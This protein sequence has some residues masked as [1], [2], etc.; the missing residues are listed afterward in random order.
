MLELAVVFNSQVGILHKDR[1]VCIIYIHI[2]RGRTFDWSLQRPSNTP[3][4][5][6]WHTLS[7]FFSLIL[8]LSLKIPS[9][10]SKHLSKKFLKRFNLYV[11]HLL[12]FELG[13]LGCW[14]F[15]FL[16]DS[17]FFI[18]ELTH[19][20]ISS[21]VVISFVTRWIVCVALLVYMSSW[22]RI[23]IFLKGYGSICNLEFWC[24]LLGSCVKSVFKCF[25]QCWRFVNNILAIPFGYYFRIMLVSVNLVHFY[26]FLSLLHI[27]SFCFHWFI[28]IQLNY[29]I[30]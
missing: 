4:P 26:I 8:N 14:A 6:S 19:L 15:D 13:F 27:H 30:L 25:W 3:P 20:I 24:F 28:V 16:V 18:L 10:P 12:I 17:F 21:G 7:P 1:C 29:S 22:S 9:I 11:I 23:L 2:E 5:F